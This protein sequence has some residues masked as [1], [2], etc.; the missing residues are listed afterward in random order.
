GPSPIGDAASVAPALLFALVCAAGLLRLAVLRQRTRF[1][2]A[3]LS[4]ALAGGVALLAALA[5]GGRAYQYASEADLVPVPGTSGMLTARP[6][7]ARGLAT[8]AEKIR[9]RTGKGDGLVAFPEGELL[10]FLAARPN[11]IRHKLYLPGYLTADN[12]PEIL[13]ELQR[14]RPA[15]IV[16]LRRQTSEYGPALFGEDYGLRIGEW[17]EAT[18]R[19]T[20]GLGK[21]SGPGDRRFLLYELAE[22]K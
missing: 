12:E 1:L 15:T 9:A 19:K 14:A 6:P 20:E 10:N 2:R 5:F 7:L 3:R 21:R 22:K 17:I 13:S 16:V 4:T 8:V 18:Y 11:P